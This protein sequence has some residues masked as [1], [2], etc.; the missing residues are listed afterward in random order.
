[1]VTSLLYLLKASFAFNDNVGELYTKKDIKAKYGLN[2]RYVILSFCSKHY[3]EKWYN[4]LYGQLVNL[5]LQVVNLAMPE[6]IV[7]IKSDIV[8]GV[9]LDPIE[10]YYIIKYSDGYIGQ[11]MHPMIVALSNKVP[12]VLFDHYAYKNGRYENISSKVWDIL[13]RADLLNQYVSMRRDIVAPSDC[14]S[15]LNTFNR[16][17]AEEFVSAYSARFHLTIDKILSVI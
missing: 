5:G 7:E 14:V 8:I 16:N 9:P 2:E 1:M 10:W 15:R 17:T 3:D 13:N 4:E 11:R 6:G 12:F